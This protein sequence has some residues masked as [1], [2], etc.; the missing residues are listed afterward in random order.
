MNTCQNKDGYSLNK[1]YI[2]LCMWSARF[3]VVCDIIE[4]LDNYI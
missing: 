4:A 1:T 2:V 3:C